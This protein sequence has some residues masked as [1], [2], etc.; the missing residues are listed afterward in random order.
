[1]TTTNSIKLALAAGTLL[2]A[3]AASQA[4]NPVTFR[5]NMINLVESS[6]FDPNTQSVEVRGDTMGWGPGITMTPTVGDTNIYEA[7]YDYVGG[8][9]GDLHEA[10]FWYGNPGDNWESINNRQFQLAGGA[11]T[12]PTSFFNDNNWPVPVNNVTFRVNMNAQLLAGNF[13]PGTST[14][15]VTGGMN[16]WG[17]GEDMT[18]NP[19][20]SG[21]A[22]NIYSAVLPIS[23]F[24]G[25]QSPYYKFRL[26]GGWESPA[27]GV[28][29]DQNRVFTIAGGDQVLPIVF[30][31]DASDAD[32]LPDATPVTFRLYITN[33]TVPTDNIP[34]VKGTDK[35]Y[36]NGDFLNWWAWNPGGAYGPSVEMTNNPD[37]SD[38]YEQTFVLPKGA[39][40]SVT[41]KYSIAG[42]DNEAGFGTNHLRYVRTLPSYTF[43]V[44]AF[45]QNPVVQEISFG[46]LAVGAPNGDTVPVT[47]LGRPGVML[48]TRDSLNSGVWTTLT[49][50]SATSSTNYP[51]TGPATYFRLIKP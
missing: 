40:V 11:Q 34:F 13:V 28:P 45:G 42:W 51:N 17:D 50:T 3:A 2:L 21:V 27:S 14:I 19:T 24:P 8:S 12:M 22:S 5:V 49:E 46:D 4:Q 38:F 29:P 44:D 31:N 33:G 1:M 9:A 10:K 15:R 18:N 6:S 43:P 47:W 23:G 16:G 30:Y 7:T 39:N 36:I 48:Q 37:G 41:Y 20:L 25:S 26:N 32:L 35:I